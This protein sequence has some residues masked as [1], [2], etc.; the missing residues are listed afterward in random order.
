M[1]K[2]LGLD[3][4]RYTLHISRYMRTRHPIG[5]R[6]TEQ[7]PR[8]HDHNR[9]EVWEV[10]TASLTQPIISLHPRAAYLMKASTPLPSSPSTWYPEA[11]DTH[12]H[13][14]SVP[15]HIGIPILLV[16]AI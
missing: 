13:Q 8:I 5:R 16:V 7:Q 1:T 9:G 6:A 11:L 2:W 15:A 12:R 14:H 4:R 3:E 10:T